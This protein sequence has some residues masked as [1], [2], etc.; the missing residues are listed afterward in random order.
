M[1]CYFP[2]YPKATNM[3]NHQQNSDRPEQDNLR[4][5]QES[6]NKKNQ[7][8]QQQSAKESSDNEG[9]S[10]SDLPDSTNKN[11]GSMG[12]GQRQDSN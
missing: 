2:T 4:Q 11:T 12:S 5:Q 1:A 10:T 3:N 9:L 7:Q 8:E 6:D